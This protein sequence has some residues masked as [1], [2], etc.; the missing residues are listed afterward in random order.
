MALNH[1]AL[2]R[3]SQPELITNLYSMGE[4][5][6]LALE[7]E[8]RQG[9]AGLNNRLLPPLFHPSSQDGSSCSSQITHS[10]MHGRA[11]TRHNGSRS[12]LQT[13]PPQQPAS[14]IS[15]STTSPVK[16]ICLS[17][18]YTAPTEVSALR[19]SLDDTRELHDS[20]LAFINQSVMDTILQDMLVSLRSTIHADSLTQF[21]NLSQTFR[22]SSRG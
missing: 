20:I 8:K 9:L 14:Q 13:T 1:T 18:S 5:W 2:H 16:T 4:R 6:F 19:F 10:H 7:L 3:G 12:N 22:K 21:N 15:C 17:S 11:E